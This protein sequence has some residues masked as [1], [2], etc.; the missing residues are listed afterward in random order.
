MRDVE[1]RDAPLLA[2][3]FEQREHARTQ[4]DIEHGYRLVGDDHLRVA[5]KGARNRDELA[6][7]ARKL[8]RQLGRE[9]FDR[10]EADGL[11]QLEHAAAGVLPVLAGEVDDRP[12]QRVLDGVQW[13]E[14]GI[15]VL[16]DHL[17]VGVQLAK[18]P[19]LVFFGAKRAT[20]ALLQQLRRK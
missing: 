14:C 17:H 9:L 13:V 20:G 7:A 16:K 11:E 10:G 15:G 6:L 2:Q 4:R 12:G 1:H 3:V 19:A 18:L 5:G 8:V